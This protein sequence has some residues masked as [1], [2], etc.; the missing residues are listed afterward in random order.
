MLIRAHRLVRSW[1]PQSL[2]QGVGHL[3]RRMYDRIDGSHRYM[4]GRH[5][6]RLAAADFKCQITIRQKIYETEHSTGKIKNLLIAAERLSYVVVPLRH[7]FSFWHLVGAPTIANG[8]KTGRSIV[9]GHLTADIG[10]GL[11]QI[12]G[13]MY[14][15]GLRSGLTIVERHAHSQDLYDEQTRFTP[16]GLDATVVWGFKDVRL[17]NDRECPVAFVFQ[18]SDQELV[19]SLLAPASEPTS[20][21][22]I[23]RMDEPGG[24]KLVEVF[25]VHNDSA[26]F[27]SRDS[28]SAPAMI[29]QWRIA[30]PIAR[31]RR[32]SD[33]TEKA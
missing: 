26:I 30:A 6:D 3:R 28:Y 8:F 27:I 1:V 4:V 32:T 10:G 18:V 5:A 33:E 29:S 23:S 20:E 13:L 16:L 12:A 15:L 24:S 7:L 19:G 14:E 21:L 22:R 9:T 11:C 2:R 25:R 31:H 17:R